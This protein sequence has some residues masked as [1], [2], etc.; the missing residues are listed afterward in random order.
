VIS[1]GVH[2]IYGASRHHAC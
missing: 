2:C 1:A